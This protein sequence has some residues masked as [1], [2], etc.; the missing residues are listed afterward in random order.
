M[1]K[2][3]L[4][5]QRLAAR[6]L[7]FELT[8]KKLKHSKTGRPLLGKGIDLSVSHKDNLTRVKFVP[9]PYKIGIDIEKLD[10]DIS[11]ELFLGP[12]ITEK[13]IPF[14]NSFCRR[15][16][17]SLASGVAAFWSVKESFF[18]CLDYDLKPGKIGILS[19]LK[20]GAVRICFSEEI[21]NLMAKR[22][23]DFF[24]SKMVFAG[25]YFY[26]ETIMK[27]RSFSKPFLF[28]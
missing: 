12:M 6:S 2:A 13:E 19:I 26:S 24:S 21:K 8:G 23:L 15:E 28:L 25:G 14:L 16:G 9:A 7:I 27:E 22:R 17:L 18:K 11:A 20:S 5:K 4:K 10:A 1:T 3:R